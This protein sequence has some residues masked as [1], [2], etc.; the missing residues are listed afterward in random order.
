MIQWSLYGRI[1]NGFDSM[2]THLKRLNANLPPKGSIRCLQ[3]SE[4]QF[5][6]MKILVGKPK[7]QEKKVNSCQL[8]LL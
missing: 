8:I 2:E 5:A 6:N 7:K 1:V 3:I 4:K